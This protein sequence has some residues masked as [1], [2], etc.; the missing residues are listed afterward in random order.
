MRQTFQALCFCGPKKFQTSYRIYLC[1]LISEKHN[2]KKYLQ[3]KYSKE[4][5]ALLKLLCKIDGKLHLFRLIFD[6]FCGLFWTNFGL[7]CDRFCDLFSLFI[8]NFVVNSAFLVISI[9]KKSSILNLE[10]VPLWKRSWR[11][12]TQKNLEHVSK[13]I[14]GSKVPEKTVRFH[15]N[16]IQA[17]SS[18]W[19]GNTCVV[20]VVL[21]IPT[22]ASLLKN[23]R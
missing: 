4:N 16:P 6:L 11:W 7:I 5:F 2:G 21:R 10:N 13:E 20:S 15:G 14:P 22:K 12:W 18:T 19:S 17:L 23:P 9:R 8:F 3:K 1:V